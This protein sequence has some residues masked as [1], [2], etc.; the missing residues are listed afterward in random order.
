MAIKRQLTVIEARLNRILDIINPPLP[1][2]KAVVAEAPVEPKAKSPAAVKKAVKKVA[3]A[4]KVVKKAVKKVA[5][6][7]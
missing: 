7:K 5:K 1:A 3:A 6:K 2:V 4:K